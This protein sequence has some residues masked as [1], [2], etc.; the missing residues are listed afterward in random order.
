[1]LGLRGSGNGFWREEPVGILRRTSNRGPAEGWIELRRLVFGPVFFMC[2]L[3]FRGNSFSLDF[4]L[5]IDICNLNNLLV[6]VLSGAPHNSF[7]YS[8]TFF[9]TTGTCSQAGGP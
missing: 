9:A 7:L 4:V 6:P 5:L 1:M 2:L 8:A 3:S